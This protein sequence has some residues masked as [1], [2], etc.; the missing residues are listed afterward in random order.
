[1]TCGHDPRK[2]QVRDVAEVA[3][4]RELSAPRVL[5]LNGG[6]SSGKS[7][8]ARE[9]QAVLQGVWLRLGVDTLIEAAPPSLLVDDGLVL[10][11]DGEVSVGAN[12][13]AVEDCW[14]GGVARMAEM[15]AQIVVRTTS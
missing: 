11:E 2:S 12:L 13:A 8:T 10:G 6:S 7:S 4:V 3:T 9:L 1:M 15:G 14:M 5:V